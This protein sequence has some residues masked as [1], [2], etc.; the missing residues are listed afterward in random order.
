[1]KPLIFLALISL[2]LSSLFAQETKTL[3]LRKGVN[4]YNGVVD[5]YIDQFKANQN[6]S[7][8]QKLDINNYTQAGKI[9]E[10]SCVL[11]KFNLS[12]IPTN[13]TIISATLNAANLRANLRP[14]STLSVGKITSAW[15]EAIKWADGVPQTSPVSNITSSDLT[16]LTRSPTTLE[17]V[18]INGLKD[19]VQSW[20]ADPATNFGMMINGGPQFNLRLACSEDSDIRRRPELVIEYTEGAAA[21]PPTTPTTQEPKTNSPPRQE[22]E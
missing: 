7:T 17:P 11:I 16:K 9:I 2:T 14:E 19:L 5:T 13:A 22:E 4:N 1:M 8:L 15:T 21:T 20:V 12:Q 3:S 6:L 18:S 10:N